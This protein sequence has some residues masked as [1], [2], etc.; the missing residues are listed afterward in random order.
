VFG[1]RDSFYFLNIEPQNK[2][3]PG[4]DWFRQAQHPTQPPLVSTSSTT[5]VKGKWRKKARGAKS[6]FWS[7]FR[8]I[9]I[10]RTSHHFYILYSVPYVRDSIFFLNIE[11]QNIELQNNEVKSNSKTRHLALLFLNLF[12]NS[13]LLLPKPLILEPKIFYCEKPAWRP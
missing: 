12:N 6:K 13:L 11:P 4:F 9:K 7:L 5:A 1:I 10:H 3:C 2:A 8:R